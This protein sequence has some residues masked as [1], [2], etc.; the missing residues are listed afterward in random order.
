M[1]VK[2]RQRMCHAEGEVLIFSQNAGENW[3][4]QNVFLEIEYKV[5]HLDC[6]N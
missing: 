4:I 1:M 2:F 6:E 5:I 3:D